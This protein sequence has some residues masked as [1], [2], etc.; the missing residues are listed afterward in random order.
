MGPEFSVSDW[1]GAARNDIGPALIYPVIL[2][3]P[4]PSAT[5]MDNGKHQVSHAD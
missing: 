5:I 3:M 2:A 1:L 4:K